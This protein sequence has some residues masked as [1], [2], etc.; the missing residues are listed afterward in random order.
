MFAGVEEK[1]LRLLEEAQGLLEK[2]TQ[3]CSTGG[4]AEYP[5]AVEEAGESSG[6]SGESGVVPV[7][8]PAVC[9]TGSVSG[10]HTLTQSSEGDTRELQ[11]T[12]VLD[13]DDIAPVVIELHDHMTSHYLVPRP[14]K[15]IVI[16]EEEDEK[17]EDALSSFPEEKDLILSQ[18]TVSTT[19]RVSSC[20]ST[21]SATTTNNPSPARPSFSERL[22]DPRKLSASSQMSSG[23]AEDVLDGGR[24]GDL[25]SCDAVVKGEKWEEGEGVSGDCGEESLME[26]DSLMEEVSEEI[27]AKVHIHSK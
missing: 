11:E 24:V 18:Q 15:E 14:P 22:Q 25:L 13:P 9:E 17:F 10:E 26:F 5:V 21:H 1:A 6:N 8:L 4:D 2:F 20:N 23:S 3:L 16:L 27:F 19:A 12:V 7:E